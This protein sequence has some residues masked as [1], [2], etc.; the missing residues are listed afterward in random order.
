[1]TRRFWILPALVLAGSASALTLRPA[2]VQGEIST[3]PGTTIITGTA[4]KPPSL[5][6]VS[7]DNLQLQCWQQGIKII[8]E[9]D[10]GGI[11]VRSLL[12]Q[13]TV[14]FGGGSIAQPTVTVLSLDD[15]TCLIRS[16]E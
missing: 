15:S 9:T 16:R 12:D 10:V 7:S 2:A 13:D 3:L 11:S 4:A 6:V 5:A 8:D 14:S 1:M